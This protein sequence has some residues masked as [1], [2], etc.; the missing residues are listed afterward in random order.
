MEEYE[1]EGCF[2]VREIEIKAQV[3]DGGGGW[4]VRVRMDGVDPREVMGIVNYYLNWLS[5]AGRQ[6]RDQSRGELS[7][8]VI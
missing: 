5:Q 3:D 8:E 7:K 1:E 4:L 2:P 6:R